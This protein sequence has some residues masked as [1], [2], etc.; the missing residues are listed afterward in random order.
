LWRNGKPEHASW[1]ELAAEIIWNY[2]RF[3]VETRS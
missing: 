2:N 1:Q 3:L